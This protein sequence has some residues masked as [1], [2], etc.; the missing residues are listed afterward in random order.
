MMR[1]HGL[2]PGIEELSSCRSP[3]ELARRRVE[4]CEGTAR[5]DRPIVKRKPTDQPLGGEPVSSTPRIRHRAV[6]SPSPR[7]QGGGQH[8]E[9]SK[10][11]IAGDAAPLKVHPPKMRKGDQRK[12]DSSD[13]EICLHQKVNPI[14]TKPLRQFE[15]CPWNRRVQHGGVSS[16]AEGQIHRDSKKGLAFN[17]I[18]SCLNPGVPSTFVWG[19]SFQSHTRIPNYVPQVPPRRESRADLQ[20]RRIPS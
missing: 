5:I 20:R 1:H 16:S 2:N 17:P 18:A 13:P 6:Q 8:G 19:R 11:G 12:D 9:Q 14:P 7:A 15:T 4:S 3:P 10:N